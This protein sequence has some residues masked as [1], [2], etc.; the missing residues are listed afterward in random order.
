[1]A[2]ALAHLSLGLS[3]ARQS[4][5]YVVRNTGV[6]GFGLYGDISV[7]SGSSWASYCTHRAWF[8]RSTNFCLNQPSLLSG[9]VRPS[10]CLIQFS[11]SS[12]NLG[13]RRL[14]LLLFLIIIILGKQT[15]QQILEHETC[16]V[17]AGFMNGNLDVN[18]MMLFKCLDKQ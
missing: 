12:R 7:H 10:L 6:Q 14:L 15:S 13:G 1:M 8:L 11:V 4:S 3:H 17:R 18:D 16:F 2:C 5:M 9:I